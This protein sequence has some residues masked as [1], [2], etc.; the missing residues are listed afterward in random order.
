MSLA[1]G[2]VCVSVLWMD[3]GW[4]EAGLR[5]FIYRHSDCGSDFEVGAGEIDGRL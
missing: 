1:R 2:M 5:R 3:G 4:E